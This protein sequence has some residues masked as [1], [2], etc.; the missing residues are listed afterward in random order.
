[1]PAGGTL[2]VDVGFTHA[3]GDIDVTV[4]NEAGQKLG[5]GT[6]TD[7]N[8]RVTIGHGTAAR[9]IVEVTLY[10]SGG[11][12]AQSYT[13][14][15]GHVGS[16]GAQATGDAFEPNDSAAAAKAI[17][18]GRTDSLTHCGDADFFKFSVARAG[19]TSVRIDF[20]HAQ[21]D[22]DLRVLNGAGDR[23]GTAAG[24]GD[25]ELVEKALPVGDYQAEVIRYGDAG[26]ACQP[27]AL[28]LRLP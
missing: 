27:Y 25:N 5:S 26:G 22:L 9:F 6:S 28:T 24:T 14:K 17:S 2:N 1:V 18:A 20:T 16:G 4:Y 7:N 23:M 13:L 3:Q 19:T 12:A 11:A 10:G 8:E 15:V 21:G